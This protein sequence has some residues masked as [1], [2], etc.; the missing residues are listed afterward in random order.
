MFCALAAHRGSIIFWIMYHWQSIEWATFSLRRTVLWRHIRIH[1]LLAA[2]WMWAVFCLRHTVS[3]QWILIGEFYGVA[4]IEKEG[5]LCVRD[6]FI[7]MS[8]VI[9]MFQNFSTPYR[10]PLWTF[11]RSKHHTQTA[12]VQS[13][14]PVIF[15]NYY[16]RVWVSKKSQ[17]VYRSVH[18]NSFYIY[19]GIYSL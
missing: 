18:V 11:S 4:R 13:Y 8:A 9:P 7:L 6:Q 17:N 1:V 10:P 2:D 19:V 3:W 16:S 15:V 12:N 5:M 14:H